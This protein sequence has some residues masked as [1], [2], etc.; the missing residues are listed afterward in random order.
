MFFTNDYLIFFRELA[1]NNNKTWFD[2]N[3]QRFE[4]VAKL[5]TEQF[6][7]HLI[8]LAAQHDPSFADLKSK[9]C[10]YRVYKDVRFSKDK[11]PYKDHL[12][13]NFSPLGRKEMKVIGLYC[14]LSGGELM[15][16]GGAY[17]PDPKQ[18][19]ALR[20]YIINNMEE[21]R[22]RCEDPD[23]VRVFGGLQGEKNKRLAPELLAHAEKEPLLFN[24]QLFFS[25]HLPPETIL[26]PEFDQ[27]LLSYYDIARP[28][29]AF[30]AAAL[31]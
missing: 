21:F 10:I 22:A 18:V 30:L 14:Q 13:F 8:N 7:Q 31:E 28:M 11:T 25:C 6:I 1:Q 24:K 17:Q 4:A 16:A 9:D 23:F 19:A 29:N 27:L 12:S 3:K 15:V 26:D 2:T 5:P 20:N